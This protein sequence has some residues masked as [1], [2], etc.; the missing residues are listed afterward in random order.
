MNLANYSVDAS[1][2]D[3][4]KSNFYCNKCLY[5]TVKKYNLIRHFKIVHPPKDRHQR[6]EEP[7]TRNEFEEIMTRLRTSFQSSTVDQDKSK[8]V[9]FIRVRVEKNEAKIREGYFRALE[10]LTQ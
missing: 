5:S 4:K 1:F 6:E 3:C 9:K 10:I 8:L 7:Y 2:L